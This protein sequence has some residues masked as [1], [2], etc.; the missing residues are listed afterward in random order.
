MPDGPAKGHKFT[1]E[2]EKIMLQEYYY[3]RGWD[4]EGRPTEEKL[5]QLGL[6]DKL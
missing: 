5:A 1:Q 4:E 3:H 2:D 6:K